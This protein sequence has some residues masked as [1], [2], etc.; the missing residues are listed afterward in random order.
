MATFAVIGLGRFGSRLARLLADAGAEVIAI[1]ADRGLVE[2]IRD[3]VTLAVC[4]DS[5]DEQALESQ[6]INRVDVAVVGIG[7]NF[8]ANAL[9]TVRLKRLGI[10]RVVSRA[11]S[12]IRAQILT[13]IGAD[14]VVNPESESADRWR[15]RLLAP[16]ILDRLEV[17]EG[18][19]LV[20]ITAAESFWGKTLQ[21]LDIRRK[22]GVN[23]VAIRRPVGKGDS[24]GHK[25]ISVPMGD[26]SIAEGDVLVVIGSDEAIRSLPAPPKP[27]PKDGN[28]R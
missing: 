4:L 6:G 21:Q 8:E 3:Q 9:T 22:Y 18:Y 28:G 24:A 23:V 1:D 17:G 14:D 11:T 5:T 2:A 19:S 12:S 26:T 7:A 20:Q 15:E 16:A 27:A 25:I 10:P 13:N